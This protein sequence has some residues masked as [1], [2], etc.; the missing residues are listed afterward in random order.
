MLRDGRLAAVAAWE[1]ALAVPLLW[2]GGLKDFGDGLAAILLPAYF[3]QWDCRPG[4]S[5]S[6]PRCPFWLLAAGPHDR[7]P[8]CASRAPRASLGRSLPDGGQ[9]DHVL[10]CG[11]LCDL[12]AVCFY[13]KAHSSLE[14][15]TRQFPEATQE[16]VM[17]RPSTNLTVDERRDIATRSCFG[18][19]RNW[20]AYSPGE[21]TSPQ[22]AAATAREITP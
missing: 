5:A 22:P 9:R 20:L 6:R 12:I 16:A 19:G 3:S 21:P 18:S 10:A 8:Q 11:D 4:R 14:C 15:I 7:H 13:R 17:R 2:A 1:T